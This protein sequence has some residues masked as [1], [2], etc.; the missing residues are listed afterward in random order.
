MFCLC[1]LLL[2]VDIV[3]LSWI[4]V[5]SYDNM[6]CLFLWWLL[7]FSRCYDSCPRVQLVPILPVVDP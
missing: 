1:Q 6:L 4:V 3:L 2:V 7:L 5:D